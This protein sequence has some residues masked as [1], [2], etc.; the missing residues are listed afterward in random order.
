MFWKKNKNYWKDC[1]MIKIKNF[2][3]CH[4]IFISHIQFLETFGFEL[5]AGFKKVTLSELVYIH[6]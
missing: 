4:F 5:G 3:V 2:A 1:S 6:F